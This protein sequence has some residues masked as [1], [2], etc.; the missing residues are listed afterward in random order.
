MSPLGSVI[1]VIVSMMIV[2]ARGDAR[3]DVYAH[4][5]II[6]DA[7]ETIKISHVIEPMDG[8]GTIRCSA[9]VY[10]CS[11]HVHTI[12]LTLGEYTYVVVPGNSTIFSPK[13]IDVTNYIFKIVDFV[14]KVDESCIDT[15]GNE[16]VDMY[17]LMQYAD[18][19]VAVDKYQ[20]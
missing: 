8:N 13:D 15:F 3:G 6:N 18:I 10:M 12:D 9:P 1:F 7:H 17:Q 19:H 20:M 16:D 14:E 4:A 2:G 11:G 5:S